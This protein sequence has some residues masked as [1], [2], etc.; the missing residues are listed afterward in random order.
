VASVSLD[1]FNKHADRVHMA[2]IAQMVNVLQAMILTKGDKMLLTPTYHVF[3][4]YTVHHDAVLLPMVLDGGT[5][6]F[7]DHT[8]PAVSSTA[9]RDAAGRMHITLTNVDPNQPR[10]VNATIRGATWR[11]ASG[12]I[13]TGA[14][15]NARNTFEQLDVVHPVAFTGAQLNGDRLTVQLPPKSVVVLELR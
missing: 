11:T 14:Q 5:Y 8:M 1:A 12:R 13:L 15:M 10:T 9:S 6:K 4:M 7:A 2:N 3:E